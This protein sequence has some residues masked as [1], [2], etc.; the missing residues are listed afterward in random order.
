MAQC[1]SG[2]SKVETQHSFLNLVVH[3]LTGGIF[4]PM[5]IKATCAASGRSAA[6]GASEIRVGDNPTEA[7]VIEAFRRAAD[8]SVE[9]GGPVYV[10]F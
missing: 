1:R 6:P 7:D 10:R 8:L 9:T 5:T 4:V 3:A 2:V